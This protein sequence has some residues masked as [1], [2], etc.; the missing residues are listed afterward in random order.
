M[1]SLFRCDASGLHYT[2]CTRSLDEHQVVND[3]LYMDL[4]YTSVK[5]KCACMC[6]H[7]EGSAANNELDL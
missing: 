1:L 3:V 4:N 6:E 5:C 7:L 2:A